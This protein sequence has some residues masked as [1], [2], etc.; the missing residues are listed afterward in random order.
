MKSI[1]LVDDSITIR[2]S[3]SALLTKA[4]YEVS[5]AEGGPQAMTQLQSAKKMDLMITDLNMPG[6][7]GITLIRETRKINGREKLPILVLTTESQQ[8]MREKAKT[9][10]ANGWLVKP[11]PADDL[12][13]VLKKVMPS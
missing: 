5:L 1:L 8:T 11:I 12:L 4:G 2:T 7:D 13:M 10:G 9:A 3:I 6:M